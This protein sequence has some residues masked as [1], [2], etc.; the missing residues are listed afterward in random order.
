MSA[1]GQ[2]PIAPSVTAPIPLGAITATSLASLTLTQQE[3]IVRGT[4]VV[5]ATQ[6]FVYTGYGSKTSSASYVEL[7]SSGY[8]TDSELAS[9][10]ADTTNI[11]G[12]ANT[13]NLALTGHTHTTSDITNI[14]AVG[15]SWPE[16]NWATGSHFAATLSGNTN[17]TFQNVVIGKTITVAI[18]GSS[19][20]GVNWPAGITWLSGSAPSINSGQT[21]YFRILADSSG[22]F[23]G[24][25]FNGRVGLTSNLPLITT[26]NGA[27]AT[28]SFGTTP[29]TFCQGN[30]SRLS[31]PRT[32]TAHKSTHA[33]GGADALTP[34]DIGAVEESSYRLLRPAPATNPAGGFNGNTAAGTSAMANVATGTFNTAFGYGASTSNTI[35]VRNAAF[36]SNAL[37]DN[38]G[39]DNT[40]VGCA[41]L[42][43]AG[44]GSS[45][46]AAGRN[47]LTSNTSGNTNIAIGT[48]ALLSN[49]NGNN[50]IAVGGDALKNAN[51]PDA[52]IGI[53]SKAGETI[54]TG[55]SNIIIGHEANVDNPGRQR[56]IV[57]GRSAVSPALDGSLVI[58]AAPGNDMGNLVSP[59]SGGTSANKDLI[60]YLNGTRYLIALKI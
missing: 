31:D 39:S 36:G 25:T 8:T 59:T 41:A 10:E 7:V 49:T 23:I 45:N 47:A 46:V 20:F 44:T 27:I 54:G 32:P 9:H 11:H 26:T 5:T 17:I 29:N 35:G 14:F 52:N 24:E 40:A 58:G 21:T 2:I 19:G 30:D 13:A 37:Q 53:G 3:S 55:G 38:T 56:C 50:N 4:I 34:T 51:G 1:I 60:I 16:I 6:S 28:G 18:T 43:A 42:A 48:A 57:L 12:I 22:T 15:G 33:T